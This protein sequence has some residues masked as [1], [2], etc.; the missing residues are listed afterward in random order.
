VWKDDQDILMTWNMLTHV[1]RSCHYERVGPALHWD[2]RGFGSE[3][4]DGRFQ[5]IVAGK[6]TVLATDPMGSRLVAWSSQG[7][8]A[9]MTFDLTPAYM[10]LLKRSKR[11]KTPWDTLARQAGGFRAVEVKKGIGMRAD[12][13]ISGTR[14][15]AVDCSGVSGAPLLVAVVDDIRTQ[16]SVDSS[17]TPAEITWCL[18]LARR[19]LEVQGKRFALTMGQAVFHG[20][21]LGGGEIGR[22]GT[23]EAEQ[24]TVFAVFALQKLPAD[25]FRVEGEG[26]AA[27]VVIGPRTVRF[28]GARL[29]LE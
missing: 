19:S 22:D 18:P 28:D 9:R 24:G 23:V 8:T 14:Y 20:V 3:W 27:R 1:R 7:R 6:E 29:L 21:A 10:P 5:P 15:V 12:M 26:T 17:R 13:G 2:L 4:L 11:D 25:N 16:V